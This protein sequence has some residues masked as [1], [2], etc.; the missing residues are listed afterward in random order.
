MDFKKVL[1][2]TSSLFL[3]TSVFS[4]NYVIHLYLKHTL[5]ELSLL[6][7]N[8]L[9]ITLVLTAILL[10]LLWFLESAKKI[11][12]KHFLKKNKAQ[13]IL[14]IFTLLT[15]LILFEG[16]LRFVFPLSPQIERN[17]IPRFMFEN[18]QLLQY[19]MT[20][21]F[22]GIM[23]TEEYT[24]EIST[25][26]LHLRNREITG[27]E[28]ILVL[29]DSF[30][31]GVGVNDNQ[32]YPAVL[33]RA[34]KK[35]VI[36]AGV[37]GYG[38]DQ[39]LLYLK[40]RGL[41][42]KPDLLVLGFFIGNDL[43][44]NIDVS[45]FSVING[46]LVRDYKKSLKPY[47]YTFLKD[48][49]NS[50]FEKFNKKEFDDLFEKKDF[51]QIYTGNSS[52]EEKEWKR[53]LQLLNQIVDLARENNIQIII[54][55]IPPKKFFPL[56]KEAYEHLK[57]ENKLLHFAETKGVRIVDLV[58]VLGKEKDAENFYFKKDGHFSVSGNQAV[59]KAL[60]KEIEGKSSIE[61]ALM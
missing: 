15:F 18:D 16:A 45:N 46:F 51:Y 26:N 11:S 49:I 9:R 8:I 44:D 38:T 24:S 22:H 14:L 7:I 20:A 2:L 54:L 4:N 6:K 19:Q 3:I 61:Y 35:E 17:Y 23:K 32:T 57:K 36:N 50:F 40:E 33:E 25:N 56:D 41:A 31:F 37:M 55:N 1:L 34:L 53:T 30:T 48:K 52:L 60:A 10:L 28:K 29:G 59:G 42:L 12:I 13:I 43:T 58:E 39:E 21:H 47:T 5:S 27:K